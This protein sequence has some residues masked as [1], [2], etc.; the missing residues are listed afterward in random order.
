MKKK[1]RAAFRGPAFRRA[2]LFGLALSV[3][4]GCA[5]DPSRRGNDVWA[6]LERGETE[7]A[8]AFF[9]GRMDVNARDNRGRTPL[10]LAVEKQDAGLAA[11]FIALGAEADAA[12]NAGR[13]PLAIATDNRDAACARALAAAGARIHAETPSGS[14]AARAA[15]DIRG[16]FL[17]AILTEKSLAAETERGR[18]ILHLAAGAGDVESTRIILRAGGAVNSRDHEGR[19]PL[20]LALS[21]TDNKAY[22]ETAELL[23]RSGGVSDSPVYAWFSPAVRANN[24]NLR[25][26]DGMTPLHYAAQGGHAGLV[27]FLLTRA[28]DINAKNASGATALH[29]AAR[30]GRVDVL[31]RLIAEGANINV[32]DAKGNSVMHIAIPQASHR[33]A[34][35]A[36][37]AAGANCNL[38]D[39]HGDSPLHIIITLNRSVDTLQALLENGADVSIH[40][41]AG[42]TPLYLAVQ[43]NK[44]AYI[45]LLLACKSDI[46]AADNEGLTP[47]ERALRNDTPILQALITNESVLQSDSGGNTALHAAVKARADTRILG[48]I[49]DRRAPVN[50]RN[51]EGDTSL[52]LAVRIGH[53]EGG[54]L[55]LSRGADIFAP[56]ARGDSP[57]SLTFYSPGGLREWMLT[58]VTLETRDGLGNT[59]LHYA[60]Q[61]RLDAYLPL[62]IQKGAAPDAANATGETPLFIAVKSNAVSTVSTL[63]LSGASIAWRDTTGNSALHTAVRW[64]ARD[65]AIALIN[66]GIDV[67][68][69]ALSGNTP[70]HDAVRLGI[71][72][73]ETILVR[74]G[75]GL[76]IRDAEGNTPFMEAVLAGFPETVERLANYGADTMVRNGR[77][78]TPLHA[79][80]GMEQSDMAQ[81]HLVNLLLSWGASIHAKNARGK[82]PLEI[83]FASSPRMVST[84]LTRDR[85]N[86][87]DDAGYTPLH[88]AIVNRTGPEI[89]KIILEQ[90]AR[91]SAVDAAGR[92]PLRA[93][94]DTGSWE[95][96]RL[97]A[98][99]GADPFAVAGDGKTPA[100]IAL[101]SGV[102]PAR[103]L[104]SGRSIA[105]RDAAGNT[106]LH[107][108][109]E[110]GSVELIAAL[111][112][113]GA[114]R[115]SR[116]VAAE[117]PV[118]VARRWNRG[119]VVAFLMSNG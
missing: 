99:A 86:V 22:A 84:L 46:F 26:A 34:L 64:N 30:S 27:D 98:D 63:I 9:Q 55:L 114:N 42:K 77:G 111:L 16:A 113:L 87:P 66:A 7:K 54:A 44:A 107:Y 81:L 61:W 79:A 105:A 45:P 23:I 72:E 19:T 21:R 58:P 97:L 106:A 67:N 12:D 49:L 15:L 10:H 118:D 17:E 18:T 25:S 108:A 38:R 4:A 100:S 102:A 59:A 60:A 13:T 95:T 104:F 96:A 80:V 20:D 24:F 41:I 103:A 28:V 37:L 62:L 32:Q 8:Q 94:V 112:E 35:T 50:A 109:A 82:T 93:A 90:G 11:F 56:N 39:E 70:L 48:L 91:T 69:Q 2:V 73:L 47:F 71:I 110:A 6:L 83:A 68:A 116:N 31:S 76:E 85:I 57:I 74:A 29:E 65:A 40:N 115:N 88:I 92:T 43:E 52:H 119:D 36:L 5:H 101:A 78:D 14:T 117:S 51:K 89:V 75:A 1:P 53:G 3:F 33:E